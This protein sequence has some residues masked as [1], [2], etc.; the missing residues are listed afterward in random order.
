MTSRLLD[1]LKKGELPHAVLVAGP[2]G[3]GRALLAR[4]AAA[5]YCLGSDDV[6]RLASC[7]NYRELAG[8]AVK[9]A[10]VRALMAT[11]AV[12]SFNELHR[13][14]VITDAH[15][16]DTRT[17]NALLKVLEEPPAD[18]MLFLTGNEAGL[19]PTIRSRCIVERLGALPL[20]EVTRALVAEGVDASSARICTAASD[21]VIGLA[22]YYAS[23]VGRVFRAEA[24]RLLDAALFSL[25]P[26]ADV[27]ALLLEDAAKDGKKKKGDPAKARMLF[28]IW[29]GVLRDALSARY[30]GKLLNAD[31]EGVSKRIAQRFTDARIE[32]M[33][34]RIAIARRRLSVRAS[35]ALTVDTL[36]AQMSLKE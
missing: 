17:Q 23:D 32:G 11:A 18:T 21:G 19:L 14:F 30:G 6:T 36:L 20:D 34:E 3:S 29:E 25:S 7:P 16:L 8:D 10:D 22:R 12:K 9:I 24:I 5:L 1:Q 27:A 15:L 4:R 35:V 33:I 13:A 2:A 31:A 26:F 28:T